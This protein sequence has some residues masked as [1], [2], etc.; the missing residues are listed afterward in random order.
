MSVIRKQYFIRLIVRIIIF[1]ICLV[2]CFKPNLYSILDGMKFF[3][4]FHPLHLLWII[5]M[6]LQI[7]PIKNKL[8]LGSQKLFTNRFKPIKEK[9]KR[10]EKLVFFY[11][12]PNT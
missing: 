8:P 10:L 11:F 1:I 5:D 2:M 9:I 12:C 4:S 6:I 7:I 3:N